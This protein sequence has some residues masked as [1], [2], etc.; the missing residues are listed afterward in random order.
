MS[1]PVPVPHTPSSAPPAPDDL[2]QLLEAAA[3]FARAAGERTLRDFGREIDPE[4]K[5]DGTP[6]TAT[7]RAAESLLRERIAA[8]FPTH[9]IL[10]EE[11]GERPGASPVRWIVDPI[12]GTRSFVRGVP[13]YAVL[14]GIEWDREPVV[15]VAHFPALEWT[16]AAAAGLG[17]ESDGAPCTVSDTTALAA[18]TVC[19]TDLADVVDG[20]AA[21]GLS[22]LTR[23]AGLARTWGDAYGHALVAAGRADVMVDPVLSPWDAAPLLTIV[24]EAGGAFTSLSGEP[25]I[26]AGSGVST[27][28]V[29]HEEV[30][31]ILAGGSGRGR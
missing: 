11:F 7:D 21:G 14:I 5:D 6:V 27:N 8:R 13:L 24:R 16:V 18:A 19:T 29:L 22:A 26:H 15:G 4:R 12:D 23:A 1:N 20:P 2:V 30:L 28:G 3:A 9:G 31:R 25:S 10:G 17:C